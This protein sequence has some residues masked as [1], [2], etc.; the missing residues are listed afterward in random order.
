MAEVR[1]DM[2]PRLCASLRAA[3]AAKGGGRRAAFYAPR[4]G[5]AS[6]FLGPAMQ[7]GKGKEKRHVSFF[8]G[9][10]MALWKTKCLVDQASNLFF[11]IP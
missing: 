3:A 6:H 11:Q 10:K 9:K 1:A 5:W 4:M 8:C 2:V 7:P